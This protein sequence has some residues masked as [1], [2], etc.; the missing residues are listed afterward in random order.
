MLQ[1]LMIAISYG[2]VCIMYQKDGMEFLKRIR[3]NV[4]GEIVLFSFVLII[5]SMCL[6]FI[7][8]GSANKDT[9]LCIVSVIVLPIIV[10]I[11]GIGF[12]KN[13]KKQMNEGRGTW[14][15]VNNPS[16]YANIL[17]INFDEKF[18]SILFSDEFS[19]VRY[20][21]IDKETQKQKFYEE[22]YLKET[23][24]SAYNAHINSI[25]TDIENEYVRVCF[26][27]N[28][29]VISEK[30]Y[31]PDKQDIEIP[32]VPQLVRKNGK[33]YAFNGWY[34]YTPSTTSKNEVFIALYKPA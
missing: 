7:I 32:Q 11:I 25:E 18:V 9:V 13:M 12:K 4:G 30:D 27:V 17:K 29:I 22:E 31:I 28:N 1:G 15:N 19:F 14:K 10:I 8:S 3:R 20:N 2:L 26:V 34:P 21:N 5:W 24:I 33:N 16:I 23:I 6:T